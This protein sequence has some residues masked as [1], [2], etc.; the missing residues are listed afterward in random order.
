MGSGNGVPAEPSITIRRGHLRA[1]VRNTGTQFPEF[2][3]ATE[4]DT[5]RRG[6]KRRATAESMEISY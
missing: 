4:R 2:R 6:K 3:G 5:L 1:L